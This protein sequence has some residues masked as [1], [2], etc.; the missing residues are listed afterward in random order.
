[1]EKS[2]EFDGLAAAKARIESRCGTCDAGVQGKGEVEL[3]DV[4]GANPLVNGFDAGGIFLFGQ[5]QAE[6]KWV[7]Q[8]RLSGGC[9]CDGGMETK[10]SQP[11][12]IAVGKRAGGMIEEVA[13]L[14]DAEPGKRL[15]GCLPAAAK[16]R[17]AARFWLWAQRP[18]RI[19]R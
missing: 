9:W 16:N 7:G 1:M 14:V 17:C 18:R 2:A 4:A 12:R 8:R 15:T 10:L 3:I 13:L 11:R 19:H 5:T 6:R